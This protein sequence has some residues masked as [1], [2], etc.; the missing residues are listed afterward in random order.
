MHTYVLNLCTD[1]KRTLHFLDIVIDAGEMSPLSLPPIFYLLVPCG[2]NR[3]GVAPYAFAGLPRQISNSNL[4]LSARIE[5]LPLQ[6]CLQRCTSQRIAP[7][8]TIESLNLQSPDLNREEDGGLQ[9]LS[10]LCPSLSS[11]CEFLVAWWHCVSCCCC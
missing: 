7:S 4:S 10:G 11:Y 2:L 1:E 8:H 6:F 5:P 3:L 9:V